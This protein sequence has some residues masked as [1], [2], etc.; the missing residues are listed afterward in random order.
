[1]PRLEF[2]PWAASA[3]TGLGAE[4]QHRPSYN[5]S[6]SALTGAV[7]MPLTTRFSLTLQDQ[8]EADNISYNTST[9]GAQTQADL[10]AKRFQE[11]T[12]TLNS[13]SLSA[14]LD[15]RDNAANPHSGWL[16][17]AS[18]EHFVSIGG[19]KH[20]LW[21]I[22]G[23]RWPA[24]AVKLQA[25]LSGYLSLGRGTV[26]AAAARAGRIVAVTGSSVTIAPKRFYLG[27]AGTLR[28]YNE[29]AM[30]PQDLRTPLAQLKATCL[31]D[32][33]AEGCGDS[34]NQTDGYLLRT[35]QPVASAG[36][37][38]FLLGKVEVRQS[39]PLGLE[40][41]LF[42]DLG[43]L[44]YD[45]KLVRLYELRPSAG[46][47]IRAIT[48]VGPLVFDFGFNLKPDKDLNEPTFV[49]HFSIGFF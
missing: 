20:D 18:A 8:I 35:N 46:V 39:M 2:V 43:N 47:G 37:Q 31:A 36:G 27:G 10:A 23:S 21:L 32:H 30:V 26:L 3:R 12:T 48:P 24:N 16:A 22:P 45:P 29:E 9:L 41:G 49:P 4:K 17:Q 13:L 14:T 7:E 1:V 38:A 40:L 33:A 19:E 34:K 28:G 11:G 6:R 42:V 5:M 25:G 44:W 15:R